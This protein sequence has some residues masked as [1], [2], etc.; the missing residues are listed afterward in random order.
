MFEKILDAKKILG[1]KKIGQFCLKY[2]LSPKTF[3]GPKKIWAQKNSG[4]IFFCLNKI[5]GPKPFLCQKKFG[6]KKSLAK[7]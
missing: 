4:L 5:L 2:I 3:L 7:K 1:Q 6:A